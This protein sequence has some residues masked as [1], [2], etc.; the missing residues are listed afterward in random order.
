MVDFAREAN[1]PNSTVATWLRKYKKR[2]E[3]TVS[4]KKKSW[5]EEKNFK[6]YWKQPP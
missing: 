1:I 6:Q 4:S 3:K 2:N 5:S